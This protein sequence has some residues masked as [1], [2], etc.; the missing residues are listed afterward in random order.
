METD[1][2]AVT[3][4]RATPAVARPIL[5]FL[6]FHDQY[7]RAVVY[8]DMGKRA[9]RRTNLPEFSCLLKESSL[10]RNYWKDEKEE[11]STRTEFESFAQCSNFLRD[12]L[13]FRRI[14][15]QFS[16]LINP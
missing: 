7:T 15:G 10:N 5:L 2:N 3:H 14:Q 4:G 1:E 12:A 11:H 8:N 13:Q 6:I 16:H 9:P